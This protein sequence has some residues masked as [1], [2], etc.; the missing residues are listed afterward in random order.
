MGN[1]VASMLAVLM[2]RKGYNAAIMDLD[3]T[4]PYSRAFGLKRSH[5]R[6]G[7]TEPWWRDGHQI[8]S[9]NLLLQNETDP[10]VWRGPL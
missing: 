3:I 4:G 7:R 5:G 1:H 8:M 2:Q 6:R 9:I 10:V